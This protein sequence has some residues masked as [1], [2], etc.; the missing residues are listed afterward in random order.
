MV[1]VHNETKCT[2]LPL[3]AT[4]SCRVALAEVSHLEQLGL[5]GLFVKICGDEFLCFTI[6]LKKP[7]LIA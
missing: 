2:S 6:A 3:V 4:A 7:L 1:V 5:P